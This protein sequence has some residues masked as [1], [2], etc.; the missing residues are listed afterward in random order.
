MNDAAH[1]IVFLHSQTPWTP[2]QIRAYSSTRP[3]KITT[4]VHQPR[5][6]CVS[7]FG[8]KRNRIA[9]K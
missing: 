3:P 1:L 7:G 2:H 6:A 9:Q 8:M 4:A 5:N